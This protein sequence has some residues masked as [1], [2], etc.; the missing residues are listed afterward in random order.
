M[1]FILIFLFI[2]FI[3]EILIFGFI[4]SS[5]V[6]TIENLEVETKNNRIY[7][8]GMVVKL[9]VKLYRI[10][11]IVSIKFYM[12]YLKIFGIKIYY[13]K[14]LKYEN[15]KQ[16]GEIVLNFIKK[17]KI[18]IKNLDPEFEYFKFDLNF[19]TEDAIATSIL[20]ATFSG[21]IVYLLRRFVKEY[22][23]ENYNFKIVPNY[24]NTNNF[25]MKFKTKLN[26]KML[27]VIGKI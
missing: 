4:L 20:T 7:V 18:K 6:I 8:D 26:L 11:K 13:R 27:E 17:N 5:I 19:G 23:E 25:Y 16:L 3:L 1:I 10:V 15:K 12:H 21:I 24:L 14:A 9:D 22:K 2:V